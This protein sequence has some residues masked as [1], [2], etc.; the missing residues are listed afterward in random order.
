MPAKTA[1]SHGKN[2]RGLTI[3]TPESLD[4]PV[5]VLSCRVFHSQATANVV[6]SLYPLWAREITG[7]SLPVH[8]LYVHVPL[9][10]VRVRHWVESEETV[11]G[12]LL[13]PRRPF[14]MDSVEPFLQIIR[15]DTERSHKS[16]N[17]PAWDIVPVKSDDFLCGEGC[18][19]KYP[20]RVIVPAPKIKIPRGTPFLKVNITL[21]VFRRDLHS[22]V[23][24]QCFDSSIWNPISYAIWCGLYENLGPVMQEA[25]DSHNNDELPRNACEHLRRVMHTHFEDFGMIFGKLWWDFGLGAMVVPI[26]IRSFM[27]GML[28]DMFTTYHISP[29]PPLIGTFFNPRTCDP[30]QRMCAECLSLM[31][32]SGKMMR[33]P[34]AQVYYCDSNCQKAHWKTHRVVCGKRV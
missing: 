26:D 18:D 22:S 34:C 31:L 7:V 15:Q 5:D 2:S 1:S 33:C 24:L 21:F 19:V 29:D 4:R 25:F 27:R 23:E 28:A 12:G 8:L 32:G 20:N 13:L 14:D 6:M 9:D 17:S 10:E 30:G 3:A 16:K 11:L